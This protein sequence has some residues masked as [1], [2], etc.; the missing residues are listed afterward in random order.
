MYCVVP[1]REKKKYRVFDISRYL[2]WPMATCGGFKGGGGG[3]RLLSPYWLIFLSE[4]RFFR[5]NGIYFVV[6]ICDKWGRSSMSSAPFFKLFGSAATGG[7]D[8]IGHEGT[9]PHFYKWLDWTQGWRRANEKLTKLY[10]DH[11]ESAQQTTTLCLRKTG[12]LFVFAI[13][14]L[15]VIR[16]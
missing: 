11:H 5:V 6:R 10:T 9:S 14:S 12:T 15:I 4:S 2:Y 7:A 13:T 16:L 1:C 8:S 3:G